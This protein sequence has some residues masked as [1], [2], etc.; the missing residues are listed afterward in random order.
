[1]KILLGISFINFVGNLLY[2]YGLKIK[3]NLKFVYSGSK[4]YMICFVD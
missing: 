1:M 3:W 4:V 2:R